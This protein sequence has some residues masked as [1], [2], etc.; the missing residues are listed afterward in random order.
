[1]SSLC[2]LW[3]MSSSCVSLLFSSFSAWMD[4]VFAESAFFSSSLQ[5]NTELRIR[6]FWHPAT[7]NDKMLTFPGP[8]SLTFEF[9][10]K[11]AP[12]TRSGLHGTWNFHP[13]VYSAKQSNKQ[14]RYSTQAM[15]TKETRCTITRFHWDVQ[16]SLISPHS[17]SPAWSSWA[18][19]AAS[20]RHSSPS[21]DCLSLLSA[22]QEPQQFCQRS[23]WPKMCMKNHFLEPSSN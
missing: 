6:T 23:L 9:L 13:L 2:P 18:L 12:W 15:K 19:P 17:A 7:R 20:G 21:A 5:E 1:M 11:A 22:V 14:C 4:R 16:E 8:D 10:C 3:L